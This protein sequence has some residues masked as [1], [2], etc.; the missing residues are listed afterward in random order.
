MRN[1]DYC[2]KSG[3]KITKGI[4]KPLQQYDRIFFCVL[5]GDNI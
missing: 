5:S 1:L 3:E 4:L 2:K